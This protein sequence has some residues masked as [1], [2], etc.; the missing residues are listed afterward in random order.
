MKIFSA[1]Y[2]DFVHFDAKPNED[3]FLVAK[4]FPIFAVADG[5]TQSHYPSGRYAL[6]YGAKEAA[7]IFC[8]ATIEYLE[9]NLDLKKT[10]DKEIKNA[11]TQAFNTTNE[12]IKELNIKH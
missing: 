10:D 6:P 11:I 9:N 12:G 4:K 3:A 7:E 1:T 2:Q 8:K 5:V